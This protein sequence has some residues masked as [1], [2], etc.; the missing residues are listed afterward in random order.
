MSKHNT[1]LM[2]GELKTQPA[3][4]QD[5]YKIL[6]KL[7]DQL[8][9][10]R[11][12][13]DTSRLKRMAIELELRVAKV[14]TSPQSYR[15]HMSILLR[16]LVKEKANF[17]KIKIAGKQIMSNTKTSSN[18]LINTKTRD[19]DYVMQKLTDMLID[20]KIL[21][22]HKY[23][24]SRI[25]PDDYTASSDYANCE[26]C[27]TK[28]K[29]SKIML[30]TLCTYHPQKKI[31]NK[32][33]KTHMFPCCGESTTSTSFMRLGC[34]KAEHHVFKNDS[35]PE[36]R[37]ISDF[38]K[39]SVIDGKENVL[40]LDCE[41]AFTSKGFEMVRLTIVD[42]FTCKVLFDEIVEPFG[43][44]I[45]LNT[46]FSGIH[47]ED[48]EQAIPYLDI[49]D[50]ILTTDLIN[51]NSILIGH[52]LENDLN[53]MRIIHERIIDTAILFSV[54]KYKTSLKNLTFETLSEKIQTGEHDSSQDA[55][56]TMNVI[57]K[58]I[59]VPIEQVK[60]D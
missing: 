8:T 7:F 45:D 5:R 51:R 21:E 60:W 53:V 17:K 16:D 40:A 56:A 10:C 28:F 2:P 50:R 39:T 46:L 34:K 15:F 18:S 6:H 3:P 57:K 14:S 44:I 13:A 55:I 33:S 31:Y 42:F 23:I 26:R 43:D 19:K 30:D 54:G 25:I 1:G 9:R 59:G 22:K 36:L 11:L 49:M 41:M 47:S 58:K 37:E 12:K 27:N 38:L 24:M 32:E 52:G 20:P 4:F 35:Y 29:K 48:M